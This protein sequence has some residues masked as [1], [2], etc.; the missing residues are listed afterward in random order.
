MLFTEDLEQEVLNK[1]MDIDSDELI[2]LSSY[3]SP[4]PVQDLKDLNIHTKVIYGMYST[5]SIHKILH[6]TLVKLHEPQHEI[7]YS[8]VPVHSNCYIW[9]KNGEIMYALIGSANFSTSG[10]SVNFRETLAETKEQAFKDLNKYLSQIEPQSYLCDEITEPPPTAK[11]KNSPLNSGSTTSCDMKLYNPKKNEVP[12]KSGLNWGFSKGNTVKGD[13]YI[14]VRIEDL[15]KHPYLFPPKRMLAAATDDGRTGRKN[16]AVDII[17]DDGTL[18]KGVL[19]GTQ[20]F[21]QFHYP[22]QLCSSTNKNILGSY[23]R[24]RLGLNDDDLVTKQHLD[25]YGRNSIALTLLQEGT[26]HADF[27]V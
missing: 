26:Y 11:L 15:K 27:S 2:I 17:W 9:R 10:L 16:E 13:A 18:M 25:Q 5:K 14:A 21:N 8:H 3:I 12:Q 23:I 7:L 20:A 6:D 22:K 1:H 24:S 19:E 4:K